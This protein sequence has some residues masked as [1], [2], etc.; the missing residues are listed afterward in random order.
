VGDFRKEIVFLAL[1]TNTP[2]ESKCERKRKS[3]NHGH[4]VDGD[5]AAFSILEKLLDKV[6]GFDIEMV[7]VC[8]D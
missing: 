1:E 2:V 4:R 7:D 6:A 8:S 5:A 3:L